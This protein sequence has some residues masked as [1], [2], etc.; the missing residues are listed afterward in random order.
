MVEAFRDCLHVAQYMRGFSYSWCI[1]GGWA[2][3]LFI[4]QVSRSHKDVDIAIWRKDQIA[5][6]HYLV[7]QGWKLEKA[8]EGQLFPWIETEWL[9]LPVHTIWCHH[10]DLQPE[11]IEILLNEVNEHNFLFRRDLSISHALEDA[12]VPSASGIPILA[13][14]IVLLYKAK[15]ASDPANQADFEGILPHLDITQRNWLRSALIKAHPGHHWLD[16]L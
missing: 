4:N 1:C 12:I 8:I 6:R 16:S 13:P 15:T 10:P 9:D 11:F 3:D 2:I 14:E 5:L 7:R